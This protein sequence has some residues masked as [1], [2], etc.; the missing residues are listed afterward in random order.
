MDILIHLDSVSW[1]IR[2]AATIVVGEEPSESPAT[3]THGTSQTTRLLESNDRLQRDSRV[4]R[5][6]TPNTR[7]ATGIWLN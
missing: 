4:F 6:V 2:A 1:D 7:T 3:T 5:N